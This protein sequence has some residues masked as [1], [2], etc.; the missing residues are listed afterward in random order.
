MSARTT[1]LGVACRT[2]AGVPGMKL[3]GPDHPTSTADPFHFGC[4]PTRAIPSDAA[5]RCMRPG[6]LPRTSRAAYT[7]GYCGIGVQ[8]HTRS[9]REMERP[10]SFAE[11]GPLAVQSAAGASIRHGCLPERGDPRTRDGR[12]AVPSAGRQPPAG[13]RARTHRSR[14]GLGRCEGHSGC[15]RWR[16]GFSSVRS[17]AGRARA[18]ASRFVRRIVAL[19]SDS[20]LCK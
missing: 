6:V 13:R 20:A 4:T 16:L 5:S 2:R 14:R 9:G 19:P 8:G 11:P 15:S 10:G 17:A 7:R 3:R 12:A 1:W 18:P